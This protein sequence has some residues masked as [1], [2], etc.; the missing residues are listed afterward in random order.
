[1]FH[2]TKPDKRAIPF[3][4]STHQSVRGVASHAHQVKNAEL[5]QNDE[6]VKITQ[7]YRFRVV[8]FC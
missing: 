2:L 8:G 4:A 5:P 1:V 7:F 3:P 6:I